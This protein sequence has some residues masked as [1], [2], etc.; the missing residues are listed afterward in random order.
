MIWKPNVTVAAILERDGQFLLVEEHTSRGR[1]FNQPAGHLEPGESL[2][3]AAIRE[4]LEESAHTFEPTEIIGI[5][6]WRAQNT[7]YLRF[8]F[9]G[10]LT[11]HDP[12]RRLDDGIIRAVWLSPDEIR[13]GKKHHRSPMVSQCM[14]DYLDGKRYPM[15]IITHYPVFLEDA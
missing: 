5:Y 11:A 7:T 1:L 14:E 12:L 9:T 8:A 13:A 4:T 10:L 3:E 2:V 6:Q 15:D